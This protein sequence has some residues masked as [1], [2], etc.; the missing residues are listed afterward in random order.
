MTLIILRWAWTGAAARPETSQL[1]RVFRDARPG[2]SRNTT[3]A[4]STKRVKMSRVFSA[5]YRRCSSWIQLGTVLVVR[6]LTGKAIAIG[7]CLERSETIESS[8]FR[9]TP[10]R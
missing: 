4:P 2:S 9:G 5:V 7:L 3:P 10:N 1:I 8:F 6:P